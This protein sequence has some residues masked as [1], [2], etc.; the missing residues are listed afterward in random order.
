MDANLG[1]PF[2][3]GQARFVSAGSGLSGIGLSG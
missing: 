2:A 1:E 3:Q